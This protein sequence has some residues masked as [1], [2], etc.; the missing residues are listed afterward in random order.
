MAWHPSDRFFPHFAG[1]QPATG[2]P[3]ALELPTACAYCGHTEFDGP[4]DTGRGANA[5]C[6]QCGGTMTSNGGHWMPELIGDPSNHP[7]PKVDPRSGAGGGQHYLVHPEGFEMMPPKESAFSLFEVTAASEPDQFHFQHEEINTGGTKFPRRVDISAHH[8]DTGEEAGRARYYPP[9]RKGGPLSIEEVRGHAP[10]AASALLNEIESR[11]PTSATKFLY[12]VKRNNNNPDVTGH[13]HERAGKPSDWDTHYPTLGGTVYRGASIRLPDR[14]ARVVNSSRPKEDHL[15]ELHSAIHGSLGMHWTEGEHAARL[16]AQN[17]VS[18]H[19]T[20]IPV[21]LHARTPERKDIETR[22]QQLYRGGVFP[23]GDPHSKEN[24][25]PIRKGRKVAI[26][27]MSWKPD[28]PHPDADEHGWI[29]HTYDEHQHHTALARVLAAEERPKYKLRQ[30]V[31]TA[32]GYEDQ[33]RE[34]EGPLYHGGRANVRPGDHLTVGQKTNSW[35]DEGSKSTHNYFTTEMDTAASYAKDLGRKGRI[36]EV[37]PTGEFKSDYSHGDFKTKHPLRVVR[38]VPREE[39]PGW[40]KEA[41]AGTPSGKSPVD[42]DT[43]G[44]VY[45]HVYG[46]PEMHGEAA[47]HGDGSGIGYAVNHLAHDRP[48]DPGAENSSV[49]DLEF[50]PYKAVP[51]EHIDYV[52][53][54]PNDPRV[55]RAIEGYKTNPDAVPPL[56]LVHRHDV[57]HVADGHHRAAA[58]AAV[59]VHPRA[60]VAFS[61]HPDEPF[62]D[63]GRGP[64]HGAEPTSAHTAMSRRQ[65][66]EASPDLYR[67][68]VFSLFEANLQVEADGPEQDYRMM[69]QA[70]DSD[71]GAPLHDVENIM[72]GFYD[73]PHNYNFG[74]EHYWD[75]ASKIMKARGNPE[76]KVRIYRALPGDHAG[77]GFNTGDWVSTSKDYARLHARQNDDPKHDWPVIS[78]TVPAKHLHTEGDVHEWAYNGPKKEWA[79]VSFKGG[80]HHEVRQREDGTIAPVKRRPKKQDN[81]P[82]KGFEI[83]HH[84][85]DVRTDTHK[86][87]VFAYDPEGNYAGQAHARHGEEP[88]ETHLA[89]EHEGGPLRDRM[90]QLI[91]NRSQ[92]R[93]A[94]AAVDWCRHRH[95]G[96]CFWPGDN[97]TPGAGL[98]RRGACNWT[99]AWEQQLCPMSDPGPLAG[100]FVKGTLGGRGL[101]H[102]RTLIQGAERNYIGDAQDR[103]KLV[104]AGDAG[105]KRFLDEALIR[106]ARGDGDPLL[107]VKHAGYRGYVEAYPGY[108]DET[109]EEDRQRGEPDPNIEPA[110]HQDVAPIASHTPLVNFIAEHFE[111]HDLWNAKGSVE[112]VD[113][114]S[115]VYATQPYVVKR[116]LGRYRDN[117]QDQV[118]Y[119]KSNGWDDEQQKFHG[120]HMPMFVRHG[121]EHF[122]IEGHHRTGAALQRGDTHIRGIVYDADKH[123]WPEND[124]DAFRSPHPSLHH[125]GRRWGR[126]IDCDYEHDSR[127][128]EVM[129]AITH[130]D[131]GICTATE[132]KRFQESQQDDDG[133]GPRR[134]SK[135]PSALVPI[136]HAGFAGLVE[137]YSGDFLHMDDADREDRVRRREEYGSPGEDNHYPEERPKVAGTHRE[138]A[139]FRSLHQTDRDMWHKHGQVENVD[140]HAQ[141]VYASQGYLAREHLDRYRKNPD[142]MGETQR[143]NNGSQADWLTSYPGTHM[144]MFIRHENNLFTT[145]GHHRVGAAFLR[146]DK[147]IRGM[148]YDA[149]KHGFQNDYDH[150]DSIQG[151][152][153][154][155]SIWGVPVNHC[156]FV[157]DDDNA[158]ARHAYYH[159]DDGVCVGTGLHGGIKQAAAIWIE[160]LDIA[161]AQDPEVRLQFTAT[162]ADVRDKAKRIRHEGGV[163][164]LMASSEGVVGEVRGDNAVYETTL[165]YVPGSAR[166]GYWHCGCAW[167]AYA[168]GRSP[169][170]RR[171]EGRFCSHALALQYESMSRSAHG[172]EIGLD[173]ERPGW[174][175][176][177]TP[178][179]IQ[180]QRDPALDLTRREVPPG[181]MRRVFSSWEMPVDD[182]VLGLA[183]QLV[184]GQPQHIAS[185]F[186]AWDVPADAVG[187]DLGRRFVGG[188]LQSTAA[189]DDLHMTVQ[190]ALDNAR[191]EHELA[192]QDDATYAENYEPLKNSDVPEEHHGGWRFHRNVEGA[193][194]VANMFADLFGAQ[195]E[196]QHMP[197]VPVTQYR[198]PV[199]REPLH[200]DEHGNSYRRH[201]EWTS[202]DAR[203]PEF[204]GWSGPHSAKET[205]QTHPTWS[206]SFDE[207]GNRRHH[208][209]SHQERL[210]MTK[211]EPT[212]DHDEVVMRRNRNLREQGWGVV[213][214]RVPGDGAAEVLVGSRVAG[215]MQHTAETNPHGVYLRFGDWSKDERSHNNVTGFKEEGISTYDL[216]HHGEPMDPDPHFSRGH[217][218]DESCDEDCQMH[219]DNEDY[220]NDTLEEMQGRVHRAEQGRRRG[221]DRPSERAHLVKGEMAGIGH[222]GE[223]LLRNVRR[224]GDW[225]D[226]RHILIPGAEPHHL[227]RDES[228]E[229]YKAPPTR[230]SRHF[231]RLRT[232]A[233]EIDYT[234]QNVGDGWK[235]NRDIV[236]ET[237]VEDPQGNAHKF[238]DWSHSGLKN[239]RHPDHMPVPLY[240]GTNREIPEGAQI[241]PGH[242]GNFVKRMKHVYLVDDP[243]VARKYAGPRGTVY[244]VQ[245]T[246]VYGHRSDAKGHNWATEHPVNVVR[247]HSGPQTTAIHHLSASVCPE[248]HGAVAPSMKNCPH[249]GAALMPTDA[250]DFHLGANQ[251]GLP[252]VAGIVLKALDTGRILMLQR[253]LDDAKDP[254]RGTWEFPGGHVEDGDVSTVHAAIREWQEEVG[255]PFPEG[256]AV[257]HSWVSPN[258]IYAGYVAAIPEERQLVMSDGRVVPNPDD[259]KGDFHEQAAWWSIEHARKNPALRPECKSGTPWKEIERAGTGVKAARAELMTGLVSSGG[260][261]HAEDIPL[262]WWPVVAGSNSGTPMQDLISGLP[263]DPPAHSN[264]QN[265]AST[266]F[267]TSEDP[268]DWTDPQSS[269]EDLRVGSWR[270][271]EGFD[272]W[273]ARLGDDLLQRGI[274]HPQHDRLY[275]AVSDNEMQVAKQKGAFRS[276]DNEGLFVSDDP[277]RLAGGA[278]G[279][280]DGGH[281]IEIDPSKVSVGERPSYYNRRLVEKAADHVPM[282][283][284]TR[285]WTWND[286]AQDHLPSDV[287]RTAMLHNEPEPAL[288]S[289]DGEREDPLPAGTPAP[290]TDA[291]TMPYGY[292]DLTEFGEDH[293]E[294][295]STPGTR[296][297]GHIGQ[298][299]SGSVHTTTERIVAEFQR[300]AGAQALASNSPRKGDDQMDIAA[301]ARA[302]LDQGAGA[303]TQRTAL[304]DFSP[305]ERAELINEGAQGVTA[306]NLQ[307]LQIEGTHYS[308]LE[309]TL[310]EHE[311]NGEDA[312]DLF[313]V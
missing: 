127:L 168:W 172:R 244:E 92:G 264:S 46:D 276:L 37:E 138:M 65:Y 234:K 101:D 239:I 288:P 29:H 16:F 58:A 260:A 82:L 189:N 180:H 213:G 192:H 291:E 104:A 1:D 139:N 25:V 50:H 108:H 283:A 34:V 59:G 106:E 23:Y 182:F 141:P 221:V 290:A 105:F 124:T 146:G 144:P 226:H 28:A 52:R 78:T 4:N 196:H 157:H 204:K 22:E 198:H 309:A 112:D 125:Y 32:N 174:L 237:H 96:S 301:A 173:V 43:V 185:A 296:S 41:S 214:S 102:G 61:P 98:Q 26:T 190:R 164:I 243:E 80:Y 302:Y 297:L 269:R 131:D 137:K 69:H 265:P 200:L 49:H 74:H 303:G 280:K 247:V 194:P 298:L 20:D 186:S 262:E 275:R 13:A 93:T 158:G 54:P 233:K 120:N 95:A 15:D 42:W 163:R 8:P 231:S 203:V 184:D 126:P 228:D 72:P 135:E 235:Y 162:W 113:L 306:R 7:S 310:C 114:K 66:G 246:G 81:D 311:K 284:V 51:T 151:F 252:T 39:W 150:P 3:L 224:V 242:P 267:A 153:K 76:H 56:V 63:G 86:H 140:L 107:P 111:N 155:S 240:H 19:R 171:F 254:A 300:T 167:A 103:G 245:P 197:P 199:G 85:S 312:A 210:E 110:H 117:P 282:H 266:G 272:A 230:P 53:H 219:L 285:S 30:T 79:T 27:G 18:D 313:I 305:E 109:E 251:K 68:S 160:A 166:V 248:C 208:M 35:G 295:G 62:S 159:H 222:D 187:S 293:P 215:H 273:R 232:N 261:G 97:P 256:A 40:A 133:I 169:K 270:P 225:I 191:E 286:E 123:G 281:I 193:P 263:H 38:E 179:V 121:G 10:G 44:S 236:G 77:K 274:P 177:R 211:T 17:A 304:K 217:Q 83:T 249:C 259:P 277:D 229:E 99:T 87:H 118:D 292:D 299:A 223:P 238:Y 57:Y 161:V 73:N 253:G 271:H 12:E 278:Y 33:E 175:K 205:L 60:L 154:N 48:D 195:K 188:Y 71:Y 216:D 206:Q 14:S 294:V 100:M 170:Y 207:H 132:R 148:V 122:T 268:E 94:A 250:P 116:H 209:R 257:L 142:D 279:G 145:E 181:N 308:A 67:E 31:Q 307:E 220:G 84:E 136:Q 202:S 156:E 75:S 9:K 143:K 176:Q 149:D 258:G 241:E 289:T 5:T 178:V 227:A 89:P 24:E 130:H 55:Q 255:Q 45:P 287:H 47:E 201:Y 128:R 212:D 2:L 64:S 134:G 119:I 152:K 70:P 36:Y 147:T 11:H 91:R 115:G 183:R 88:Y 21:V 165:S 129:H 90:H 6:Q 218:H